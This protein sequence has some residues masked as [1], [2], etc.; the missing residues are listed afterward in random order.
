MTNPKSRGNYMIPFCIRA[1]KCENR[2]PDNCETCFK[3]A[4]YKEKHDAKD[5]SRSK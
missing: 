1:E 3:Y 5:N 2:D 4:N